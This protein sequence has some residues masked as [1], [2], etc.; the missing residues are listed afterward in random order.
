MPVMFSDHA[1]IQIKQRNITKS[2][3][4]DAVKNPDSISKSFRSRKLRDKSIGSK[5][6]RVITITED[7][8]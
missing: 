2:D 3:I 8:E 7:Q 5:M 6:L 1:L 4:L